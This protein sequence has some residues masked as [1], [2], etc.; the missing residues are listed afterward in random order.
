MNF[1]GIKYFTAKEMDSPDAPGSGVRMS[2]PLVKR[3][4]TLR[5]KC[6][7]PLIIT[8][9]YRTRSH[10][11]KVGGR[12]SSEHTSGE[13]VDIRAKSSAK[14][15]VIVSEALR[16]GFTRVGVGS[17]FVHLGMSKSHPQR[18]LWTY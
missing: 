15:F 5:A 6:G 3:L 8:S 1:S 12:Y 10:N 14:R 18:V 13:A 11:R 9:A 7:F 16:L 4:D 2:L 17:S